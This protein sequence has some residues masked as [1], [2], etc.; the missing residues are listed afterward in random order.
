MGWFEVNKQGLA[1]LLDQRGKSFAVFEL[2]QNAWDENTTKVDVTLTPVPNRAE[3][4]LVVVDD[5]PDGF[6][7]LS[8]AFT[9]FAESTKKDDPSKRGR[10]NL[11]E[12]LVLALC[13]EAKIVST[14]GGF[15]FNENGER[16]TL[17]ERTTHGSTFRGLI[18]MTR[19]EYAEVCNE[20]LRLL[21]PQH[22]A[23]TFN[24]G[25]LLTRKPLASFKVTLPTV[26]ADGEGILRPS[27][28]QTD[29][30]VYDPKPGDAPT[31]YEMGIPVVET[32]DKWDID[33]QQKIPLNMDRDN[34]T[35]SYLRVLRTAV[36]NEMHGFLAETDSSATWVAD[37][38]ASPDV[39][40][41]AVKQV[42]QGRFGEKAAIYDP[43]DTEANKRLVSEGYNLIPGGSFT[44]EQ[45]VNIKLA[46]VA[47]PAGQ[48]SPSAKPYTSGG[49]P[50]TL[51]DP[52]KW[53]PGI[54][55]KVAYAEWLGHKLLR[56][57]I[58]VR[59]VC[60]VGWPF[61]ATFGPSGVLTL[62]LGRLGH[63]WFNKGP[64][65]DVDELIIHEFGHN[66]CPDHLST[67]YYDALCK[68][69][70]K[71]ADLARREPSAFDQFKAS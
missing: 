58:T 20:V 12:K 56:R 71:L 17:R 53:T 50:L 52:S 23:T 26:S 6:R 59:V 13:R 10:F 29:V 66:E 49:A 37:A 40:R 69:G 32:G 4:E 35:P 18:R 48:L 7:D 21:P 8:H 28:R 43:T 54:Q 61:G 27:K 64:C 45:W 22:I 51:L 46:G 36:L 5:N 3:A 42:V 30:H 41:G 62:N 19:A 33:I 11:G 70:A 57:Q 38:L 2:I 67:D 68:L 65:V 14:T 60:D 9:L 47:L 15:E 44:R 24:E 63:A 55:N 31:L 39:S 16:R 1:K 34:V 25:P